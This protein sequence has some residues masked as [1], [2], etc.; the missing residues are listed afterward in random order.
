ML[1]FM[2][3]YNVS[4]AGIGYRK[5]NENVTARYFIQ[6]NETLN[7]SVLTGKAYSWLLT[8]DKNSKNIFLFSN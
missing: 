8:F 6:V 5:T 2:D 7:T 4:H 1:T 3:T